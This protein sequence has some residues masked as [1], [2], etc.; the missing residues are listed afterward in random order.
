M[1]TIA[2]FW[3]SCGDLVEIMLDLIGASQEENWCL[4][5]MAVEDLIPRCFAYN[6]TNYA[7]CLS[8]YLRNMHQNVTKHP[9]PDEYL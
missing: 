6:H 4:H 7:S 3:M 1:E 8:W 9:E 5:L 2:K